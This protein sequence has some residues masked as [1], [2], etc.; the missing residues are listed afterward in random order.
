MGR[1]VQG[2]L[3][4]QLAS[5]LPVDRAGWPRR[6]QIH[7]QD[8]RAKEPTGGA[9]P[10]EQ[11][12][13]N[14]RRENYGSVPDNVSVS[15]GPFCLHRSDPPTRVPVQTYAMMAL[16]RPNSN[17]GTIYGLQGLTGT[18]SAQSIIN[19]VWAKVPTL[20]GLHVLAWTCGTCRRVRDP[21][22]FIGWRSRCFGIPP[23]SPRREVLFAASFGWTA[24]ARYFR[25]PSENML[26]SGLFIAM[27]FP[28]VARAASPWCSRGRGSGSVPRSG[29]IL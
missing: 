10:S 4:V 19:L 14:R 17:G 3:L 6:S 22:V 2:L 26:M 28:A 1:C 21:T 5:V 18:V 11:R 13:T 24:G 20:S 15:R 7:S 25:I 8:Y 16:L 12:V 27:R 29:N 23:P 9:R